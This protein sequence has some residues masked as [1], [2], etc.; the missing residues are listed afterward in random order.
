M[1]GVT[2]LYRR[3]NQPFAQIPNE[4]IRDPR[5]TSNAFRLLAYLM[6]HTDG[7]ELTYSQIE[8]QTSLGRYAINE[9]IK[10]LTV[11]GW[12]RTERTKLN[13]GQ[14]GPKSWIVLTPT[15]VGNST[16]GDS[17]MEYPTD[18][19]NNTPIE[20]QDSKKFRQSEID[21]AF[22][23]F[24]NYYPRKQYKQAV[25]K[26]FE[27]VIRKGI[28]DAETL[29]LAAEA[30]ANDPNL[31][32]VHF[33]PNG[34]KWLNQGGWDNPPYPERQRSKEELQ[35]DELAI[36]R[37]RR[38]KELARSEELRREMEEAKA[39][40][41]PAPRCKHGKNLALCMPCLKEMN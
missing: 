20:H 16:A 2:R 4:A 14:F 12:L 33:I 21:E 8:R 30:L 26:T 38:E 9:A 17:T 35:R 39:K 27:K 3:D 34:E 11:L 19:K 40:A 5:M 25:R 7:Y 28:V 22:D 37:K 24:W 10:N 18:Y 36:A 29:I 6:S 32:E 23:D 13:N 15:T 31:P 41:A 1:S